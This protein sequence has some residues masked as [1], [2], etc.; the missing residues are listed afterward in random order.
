MKFHGFDWDQGNEL[1]CQQH[2]VSIEE[3]EHAFENGAVVA[4]EMAHSVEEQRLIAIGRNRQ[5]RLL[6]IGFTLRT[7]EVG[8]TLIRPFSARYMHKKEVR[9]Y[10]AQHAALGPGHDE[11]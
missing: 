4:P 8:G 5:G 7:K 3:I 9:R 1:K 10:E 11:R 2:G 6:F